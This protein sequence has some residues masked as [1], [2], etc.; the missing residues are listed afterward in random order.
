MTSEPATPAAKQDPNDESTEHHAADAAPRSVQTSSGAEL[1]A[2]V[3]V[4][5]DEHLIAVDLA[6]TLENLGVEVIGPVGNGAQAVELARQQKPNLAILDIRMP[7]MDGLEAAGVLFC[8]MGIPV[9]IVSAYSDEEYVQS[10]AR[11]GVFGYLIKP[12]T[13]DG[14]PIGPGHRVV[15]IPAAC[16][17]AG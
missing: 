6:S 1:P 3:L 2:R 11:I 14:I 4:A 17:V 5:E 8:Q 10:A 9:V 13:T 16:R 7:S 12:V 15:E